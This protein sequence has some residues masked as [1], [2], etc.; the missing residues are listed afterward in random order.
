MHVWRPITCVSFLL[1][2]F[3]I[4][5]GY[6]A[7]GIER[8][9]LVEQSDIEITGAP[10]YVEN[11]T[12]GTPLTDL[13]SHAGVK[14]T[15]TA[16]REQH[17]HNDVS[18]SHL[19]NQAHYAAWARS[20][21]QRQWDQ[22][23]VRINTD[24]AIEPESRTVAF[25]SWGWH[26]AVEFEDAVRAEADVF[27]VDTDVLAWRIVVQNSGLLPTD[28]SLTLVFFRDDDGNLESR[29]PDSSS[30]DHCELADLGDTSLLLDCGDDPDGLRER[31][32]LRR[33]G[34]VGPEGMGIDKVE[35][36]SNE[37][38]VRVATQSFN[39]ASG[40]RQEITFFLVYDAYVEEG[41]AGETER[42]RSESVLTETMQTYVKG[43]DSAL[44]AAKKRWTELETQLAG[45]HLDSGEENTNY[46][47]DRGIASLALA[48]LEMGKYRLNDDSLASVPSKG[49]ESY[50][51][52]D[53]TA[54]MA[55]GLAEYDLDAAME[56]LDYLG[57]SQWN[58][59]QGF[60]GLLP[61]LIDD[62]AQAAD[63][64][65]TDP[66][67]VTPMFCWAAYQLAMAGAADNEDW[68]GRAVETCRG[69]VDFWLGARD[70][71]YEDTP[72]GNGLY[73]YASGV[74][75]GWGDSPR[76]GCGD[77]YDPECSAGQ[78]GAVEAL[79]LNCW[80]A[81]EL[82]ALAGLHDL[83][84]DQFE[85]RRRQGEAEDLADV[86]ESEL[87]DPVTHAYFDRKKDNNKV[88]FVSVWTPAVA[89]PLFAGTSRTLER[90]QSTVEALTDPER[91]GVSTDTLSNKLYAIPSVGWNEKEYGHSR[92]GSWMKGQVDPIHTFVA[93]KAL[94]RYGREQEAEALK[95][96]LLDLVFEANPGG[97][98]AA[99][100]GREALVGWGPGTGADQQKEAR[101]GLGEPAAFLAGPQAA[102]ILELLYDRHQTH[103]VLS[104]TDD[105]VMGYVREVRNM[106]D[107]QL[108]LVETTGRDV[109]RLHWM[110]DDTSAIER[111]VFWKLSFS[112]PYEN[113][114][115]DQTVTVT[116]PTLDPEWEHIV[117]VAK[118]GSEETVESMDGDQLRFSFTPAEL[119]SIDYYRIDRGRLP[120]P[121]VGVG[122][123]CSQQFG[124]TSQSLLFGM[125]LL[126]LI[127]IVRGGFLNRRR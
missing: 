25:Q 73:E 116:L 101:F 109:P 112:D 98:H 65:A 37:G 61:Y 51:T 47:R 48:S 69:E 18:A 113:L 78:V 36:D 87:W 115:S 60:D 26:E 63:Q 46:D 19:L 55:L 99:Y 74:E 127:L 90:I 9:P 24:K 49:Y 27:F 31:H 1:L 110:N 52:P 62:M 118:D 97:L 67:T 108:L 10:Y 58:E 75:T 15:C 14:A 34:L 6:A 96:S 80:L 57:Q 88:S 68:M 12:T 41:G 23:Y 42:E 70:A 84:G 106:N 32:F 8:L 29:Y 64:T 11:L 40:G 38:V 20:G 114:E 107:D 119:E 95:Q 102:A 35:A 86:I 54:W 16:D 126:A 89:W 5:V 105:S 17:S 85:A 103:R 44:K 124:P 93:A 94:Y 82:E 111:A 2:F 56:I 59:P 3:G 39:V 91:L 76:F 50:I 100:D 125:M 53:G 13:A 30:V 117:K 45:V 77:G 71:E 4:S 83:D 79:D 121:F 104:S 122:S 33:V 28:Y 72:G 66:A 123:G 21:L 81:L 43:S 120:Y 22:S 7:S 92:D